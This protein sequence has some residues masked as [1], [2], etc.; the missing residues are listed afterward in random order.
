[1]IKTVNKNNA[2]LPGIDVFWDKAFLK[3]SNQCMDGLIILKM[4]GCHEYVNN[5]YCDLLGY[6]KD[7]LLQM[8]VFDIEARLTKRNIQKHISLVSTTGRTRFETAHRRKDGTLVEVEV[9]ISNIEVLKKKFFIAVVRDLTKYKEML[10]DVNAGNVIKEMSIKSPLPKA[11]Y[12]SLVK[13]IRN[14]TDC[15]YIGIRIVKED[16]DI[17]YQANL[18]FNSEFLASEN[19]IST[20][21]DNCLCIRLIKQEPM[22]YEKNFISSNGSFFHNSFL[23]LVAEIPENHAC[24]YCRVCVEHQFNSMAVIP[25]TYSKEMLG[26]I[27]IA[28]DKEN[29]LPLNLINFMEK[30]ANYI[31]EVVYRY[32]MED[33]LIRNYDLLRITDAIMRLSLEGASLT[34]ILK[35]TLM[36]LFT[37]S[38]NPFQPFGCIFLYNEISHEL[39]LKVQHRILE[40]KKHLCKKVPL[41]KCICGKAAQTRE[42]TFAYSSDDRHEIKY[43]CMSP[44]GHFCVPII[45]SNKTLGV[46]NL[47]V[48]NKYKKQQKDEEFL[49]RIADKLAQVIVNKRAERAL[50]LSEAYLS[51]V[52]NTVSDLIFLIKVEPGDLFTCV[53][54]NKTYVDRTGISHEQLIGKRIEDILPDESIAYVFNKYKEAMATGRHIEYTEEV[55]LPSGYLVVNTRLTPIYDRNGVCTH[56]MGASNDVTKQNRAEAE[57]KQS[58][59]HL[60]NTLQETVNALTIMAEKRDPYTVGHQHRVTILASGIAQKM[61]CSD[62]IIQGIKISGVLHDIGKVSIPIEILAKPGRLSEHEMS[63]IKTHPQVGF[64]IL[65][66]IPFECPVALTVLQ[67]HERYDGSG[68]PLG[69]SGKDILKEARIMAVADVVE[70]MASHRPYRPSLGIE[71][72]LNEIRMNRGIL[73]DPEVVD[74]CLKLFEDGFTFEDSFTF[75]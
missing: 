14:W 9:T 21:S 20:K 59:R 73:Y 16:G 40:A 12:G 44:H 49:K 29:K 10:N 1:M 46:L 58:F 51:L 65:Q 23:K 24:H 27:Q 48:S 37:V 8:S 53:L 66:K 69:L 75:E 42:I 17:P 71:Q 54:V 41:G 50:K 13:M 25:I 67:H 43:K 32:K 5:A 4:N 70:A 47:Y 38:W 52:H 30:A 33:Q 22:D 19:C 72:A 60:R 64:E 2:L 63:I 36:H 11:F 74:A 28:D 68:Y 45:Y 56:L 34:E 3:F 35:H 31:G 55:T 15:R 62:I 18:G 57:L 7:E 39:E 61:G 6:S 26:I